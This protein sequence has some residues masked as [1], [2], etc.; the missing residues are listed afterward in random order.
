MNPLSY[1]K[2]E[3]RGDFLETSSPRLSQEEIKKQ[4]ATDPRV[5]EAF[6]AFSRRVA[7]REAREEVSDA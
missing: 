5:E 6:E 1:C 2:K 7:E 3:D 4:P